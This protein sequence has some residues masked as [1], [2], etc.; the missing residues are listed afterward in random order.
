MRPNRSLKLVLLVGMGLLLACS[1]LA[2]P[3]TEAP[4]T[5]VT[6]EVVTE[7]PTQEIVTV[8]ATV[9]IVTKAPTEAASPSG[10]SP[11][12]EALASQVDIERVMADLR[13]LAD[14]ERRGRL[15]GSPEENEVGDWL[16]ARFVE[17]GLEPFEAAGLD[18]YVQAFDVDS[19]D[20]SGE[21]LIAVL[22]GSAPSGRYV[23]VGAHYDHIGV[24]SSG[25]VYNGAD[26]NAAGVAVMLETAR[27]LAAAG[28]RPQETVVFVAF[29]AEEAGLVGSAAFCKQLLGQQL[30]EDSILL[31]LEVLGAKKGAGTVL[32]VWDQ[33]VSKTAALVAAVEAAGEQQ[34]FPTQR[35]GRDPGSDALQMLMCNVPAISVSMAWS[36]E[37]HPGYH[38]VS[39][40]VELI[41]V[42]GLESA[43]RVIVSATWMLAN[44]E[45]SGE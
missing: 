8:E 35:T 26:D 40:D 2:P 7:A 38:D 9:E 6:L 33:K 34:G 5:E 1:T 20:G 23:M 28:E 32:D 18:G 27:L 4:V 15:T 12:S 22:P 45:V 43:A 16:E 3:E 24:T 36:F 39:D 25:K 37:N 11:T 10:E 42:D 21:N 30:T 13:W 17:L 41:D 31:N 19:G 14:D 29:S 44:G